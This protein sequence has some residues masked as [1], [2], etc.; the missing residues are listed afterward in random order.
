MKAPFSFLYTAALVA[1]VV[2]DAVPEDPNSDYRPSEPSVGILAAG[3]T[4][5]EFLEG[6]CRDVIFIYARGTTQDGNIVSIFLVYSPPVGRGDHLSSWHGLTRD[7][8]MRRVL[9]QSTF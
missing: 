5:N 8:D 9:K 2:G 6:G 7:R 3:T 1:S 4:A